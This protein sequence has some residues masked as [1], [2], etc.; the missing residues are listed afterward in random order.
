MC[1][2]RTHRQI[3][4][5]QITFDSVFGHCRWPNRLHP[6]RKFCIFY[7]HFFR[8]SSLSLS[9]ALQKSE[10]K[11][12]TCWILSASISDGVA[13]HLNAIFPPCYSSGNRMFREK[14]KLNTFHGGLNGSKIFIAEQSRTK[15]FHFRRNVSRPINRYS[16]VRAT[17]ES[18][19]GSIQRNTIE[20]WA[21]TR[22]D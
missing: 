9:L 1:C 10:Q 8:S 22:C 14:Q 18:I 13:S 16:D 19:T 17:S 15:P 7:L 5:Q 3:A 11:I 4:A 21:V 20:H 12:W 6:A 2:G